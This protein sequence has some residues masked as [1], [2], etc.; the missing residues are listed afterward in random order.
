VIRPWLRIWAIV[1][2]SSVFLMLTVGTLVT[3]FNAGM[4]DNTWPRPPLHLFQ[5]EWDNWSLVVEHSHRFIGQFVGL[6]TIVL[7]LGL[8]FT[9]PCRKRRFAGISSL[10]AILIS[11]GLG[12]WLARAKQIAAPTAG[13]AE[14]TTVSD[15]S[16]MIW[17]VIATSAIGSLGL[18]A[19]LVKVA[20]SKAPTAAP[21]VFVSITLV[22]VLIQ[23]L[24]GGFRVKLDALIGPDFAAI[25]GLFSQIV[26]A[27][28]VLTTAS[29]LRTDSP[30]AR[31]MHI[32]STSRLDRWAHATTIL[33]FL[34]VLA[35]VTLR[36][37]ESTLAWLGPRLHLWLVFPAVIAICATS[38]Q[39]LRTAA[40]TS[41]RI[42]ARLMLA[43]V[44]IQIGL[45]IES[46]LAKFVDGVAAAPLRHITVADA[47]VRTAHSLVGYALFATSVALAWQTRAGL[48]FAGSRLP[49]PDSRLHEGA[50]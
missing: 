40:P 42:L 49:T 41:V 9:D 32:E 47:I 8:W 29:V 45:G 14:P 5:I 3:S 11:G 28:I 31:R 38:W 13:L 34:Q 12:M 23:G 26:L 22:A 2:L 4:S 46:W 16:W 10:A 44:V 50:T 48:V 39:I 15:P 20:R 21:I 30:D 25:H 27:L 18:G 7:A 24:L 1:T 6:M 43:L 33:V 19:I 37:S 17:A 35:G 36:H